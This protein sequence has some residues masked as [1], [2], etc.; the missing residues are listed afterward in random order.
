MGAHLT[1]GR[2]LGTTVKLKDNSMYM[3][4]KEL[5]TLECIY[6]D[7]TIIPTSNILKRQENLFNMM[8]INPVVLQ[9]TKLKKA[10]IDED[11]GLV[12]SD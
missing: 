8:N 1:G 9:N 5:D 10:T 6:H 4:F 11:M 7:D 3:A 2:H 12:L